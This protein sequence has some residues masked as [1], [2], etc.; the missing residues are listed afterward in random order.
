MSQTILIRYDPRLIEE[1]VFLALRN[2][3]D[4][5]QYQAERECVYEIADAPERDREFG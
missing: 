3:P 5:R 4:G 1:A 2:H